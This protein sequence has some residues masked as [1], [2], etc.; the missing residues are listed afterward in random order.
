MRHQITVS[1][2][3][4]CRNEIRHIQEVIASL[5]AQT[6]G[7]MSWEALIADGMSTDGTREYLDQVSATSAH[8]RVITN[9]GRI[10]STGLNAAIREARGEFVIRMDA[11]TTYAPDYCHRS[12]EVLLETGADNVGGAARTTARGRMSRAISA[13]Y[14]SRFSTGGA[15]FHQPDYEGWA[16]TVP[17]GCWRRETLIRLGL[18][19]EQLVRNQDDELNLRLLRAGGRIWQSPQIQSWYSPRPS[20]SALFKQYSQYGFWKVLV[21]R[22]H[23]LPG[24]IR[25]LVPVLFVVANTVIPAVA[26]FSTLADWHNAAGAALA[27]WLL[28]IAAY[29]LL[30][31]LASID[32]A[33]K[34][35]WDLLP[36]LPA[37]FAT[38][39]FSYGLGFA[40]GLIGTARKQGP[41]S[42]HDHYFARITR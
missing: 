32:A 16:D 6:F 25:H 34:H 35:G 22:K 5:E 2:V 21:I 37:S 26:G 11:H 1:I 12:I 40:A 8:I 18:F 17:Y 27:A 9:P 28:M 13:A 24:S 29:G 7:D 23:R 31:L 41:G 19:D 42:S 38:F 15:P 10:V 14:H 4:A 39:H 36:Y 33:S 30:T 20:L 3:M